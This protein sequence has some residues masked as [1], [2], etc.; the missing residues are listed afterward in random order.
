MGAGQG[1]RKK[2]LRN[3]CNHKLMP[4]ACRE[5]R[6]ESRAEPAAE[7]GATHNGTGPE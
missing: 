3:V 2:R 5:T 1:E 6:C 4:D 7:E